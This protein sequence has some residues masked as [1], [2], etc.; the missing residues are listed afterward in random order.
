MADTTNRT[1]PKNLN[2]SEAQEYN[3][4]LKGRAT[5]GL[6]SASDK[7]WTENYNKNRY[8]L[9]KGKA[10]QGLKFT[11][12]EQ[13]ESDFLINLGVRGFGNPPFKD[14]TESDDIDM[15]TRDAFAA[16]RDLF[17]SYGLSSLS[18]EIMGYMTSGKT[19]GEA[20]IALKTNPNGAYAKRF[21]G[22]FARTKKGLNAMSESAYIELED[23]YANTLR[24]YGL[25]NMLSV[26]SNQNWKQFSE[27]IANDINAVEFKD[28]ISSV[29]DRVVNADPAIKAMFKEFYPS[30]T[31]K[32]L[33]AYFLNPAETIGKLK[34]KVTSA[35]IGA[36]FTGQGL[37][38]NLTSASDLARYGIDRA[39]ALEGAANIAS[40][41]P[42]STKLG[43]IYGETG[44]KYTQETGVEEFLK[45]SDAAKRK[46][47]VLASKERANF[48]GSAG[49][50]QGAFSTAYLKKSSAAGL[51]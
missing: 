48:E 15:A 21:A 51:I 38:T 40:V 32:D 10:T 26:D 6:L 22:N 16:L 43:N 35:E 20:L 23:S 8:E 46:R 9:L 30:L 45:S 25:G 42:E 19:A 36:A 3:E 11:A 12:A 50:A 4:Y 2:S 7:K 1:V 18:D 27:Y 13:A 41:L 5:Q 49:A 31:D 33:V 37:S 44:I 39:G 17:A 24:A 34:E 29:Q 28:R 14:I 47:N